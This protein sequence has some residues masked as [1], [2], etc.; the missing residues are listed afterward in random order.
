MVPSTESF[1]RLWADNEST[2]ELRLTLETEVILGTGFN[3]TIAR[4]TNDDLASCT[5]ESSLYNSL[6]IGNACSSR[7]RFV[8]KNMAGSVGMFKEEQLV[9]FECRMR[10]GDDVSEWMPQG[11]YFVQ[12]FTAQETGEVTVVAYDELYRMQNQVSQLASETK[13]S[14]LFARL[15][16]MYG[17][18]C[19]VDTFIVNQPLVDNTNITVNSGSTVGDIRIKSES[20][21]TPIRTVLQTV[22]TLSGA[23]VTIDKRNRMRCFD[24]NN[25]SWVSNEPEGIQVT[26]SSLFRDDQPTYITG[27]TLE[28]DNGTFLSSSGWRVRGR[29]SSKVTIEASDAVATTVYANLRANSTS[30]KDINVEVSNVRAD[31]VYVTPLIELF[32]LVSVDIGDGQYFNF[33]VTDFSLNYVNGCWGRLGSPVSKG[34]IDQSIVA[35]WNENDGWIGSFNLTYQASTLA[36][37]D[38]SIPDKH[39]IV[40]KRLFCGSS[41]R[42]FNVAYL[43]N[44]DMVQGF[45]TYLVEDESGDVE[46]K[47]FR[48]ICYLSSRYHPIVREIRYPDT[49]EERPFFFIK[50][51]TY[52]CSTIPDDAV[53]A[54]IEEQT[55]QVWGPGLN[56]PPYIAKLGH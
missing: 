11:K 24:I 47:S 6:S 35:V 18:V 20:A 32:D 53:G 9:I 16:K 39:R 54:E 40:F 26:A 1:A 55:L 33:Y 50:N 52:Y 13:L 19:D 29:I 28:G 38:V 34:D 25:P 43:E 22:A 45:V 41:T 3:A 36:G 51:V 12:S 7:L 23:N 14:T 31:G 56:N 42:T 15:K 30:D 10:K 21:N 49:P 4:F 46:E 8:L 48:A 5:L 27:V 37:Q 44:V 2:L 17:R